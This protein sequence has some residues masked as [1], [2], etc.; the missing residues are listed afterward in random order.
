MKQFFSESYSRVCLGASREQLELRWQGIETYCKNSK[1]EI[2]Q[3]VKLYYGLKTNEEFRKEF[4]SNFN[5]LDISF[6][7]DN[8]KELSVLA[9]NILL[10][11]MKKKEFSLL[12]TLSII[13]LSKY[14]I[15]IVLPDIIEKAYKCFG[16]MSAKIRERE[17]VC[18]SVPVKTFKDYAKAL[19]DNPSMDSTQ[20]NGLTSV[21]NSIAVSISLLVNNQTEIQSALKV[22]REDSKILSWICGEWSNELNSPLTKKI[23]QKS[24]ALIIAKELSDLVTV[25]PGPYP[26]K[27]VLKKMLDLCKLDAGTYTIVELIDIIDNDRKQSIINSYSCIARTCESTPILYCIKSALEANAIEVWKHTVSNSLGFDISIV[28]NSIFEWAELMYFECIL[29]KADCE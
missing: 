23:T 1:F 18:K 3:L 19:T 15:D 7:A 27:S 12:I 21:C 11:L 13:C 6:I 20:I 26:A 28:K 8:K 25:L 29:V 10:N 14:S 4:V 5:E 22:Y 16:E 24:I 9:G 2:H 17:Y